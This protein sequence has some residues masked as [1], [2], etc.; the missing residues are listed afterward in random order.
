M[1]AKI[2]VIANQKGGAGKTTV[3][4]QLAG[5]IG[6]S[7]KVLVVDAD[8]QG[9]ATRW[10]STADDNKPFLAADDQVHLFAIDPE[11][12]RVLEFT[13]DGEI[14]RY[15]GDYSVG[16]DGFSLVGAIALGAQGDVWVTDTGNNRVMHFNLP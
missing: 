5:T 1:A 16:N 2:I 15:W 14:V 3:S 9:T 4:M 12:V 11:G 8:P 10:A 13:S 6:K 7:K